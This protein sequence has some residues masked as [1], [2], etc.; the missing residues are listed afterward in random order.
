M[1]DT[2]DD[3]ERRVRERAHEIWVN[4][5][6]PHD[7]ADAHWTR[8]REEISEAEGIEDTLKPNPLVDPGP[9][10]ESLIAVDGAADLPGRLSDQGERQDYPSRQPAPRKTAAPKKAMVDKPTAKPAV[11]KPPAKKKSA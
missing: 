11:K 5:G 3:Y 6:K 8:A 4:E 2:Y 7:Q 9:D 10:A 1:T